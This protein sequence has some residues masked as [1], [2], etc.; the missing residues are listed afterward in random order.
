[1]YLSIPPYNYTTHSKDKLI[2]MSDVRKIPHN[3]FDKKA[4][5]KLSDSEASFFPPSSL[6]A[7]YCWESLWCGV[8]P[9]SVGLG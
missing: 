6:G 5:E 3:S 8:P 7:Y 2:P 1:M 4:I 9:E